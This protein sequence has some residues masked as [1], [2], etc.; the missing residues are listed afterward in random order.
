MNAEGL[1][2][3]TPNSTWPRI[4]AASINGVQARLRN[5]Q[6]GRGLPAAKSRFQGRSS[7]NGAEGRNPNG[8]RKPCSPGAEMAARRWRAMRWYLPPPPVGGRA[9]NDR[10]QTTAESHVLVP[11]VA[12][13]RG[14]LQQKRRWS[15][16]VREQNASIVNASRRTARI[17]LSSP[18]VVTLS[19]V[20]ARAS[21]S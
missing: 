7:R 14:L 16:R 17:K 2:A 5:P 9:R 10:K 12:C 18:A 4:R 20:D 11:S 3:T 15:E 21:D 6:L 8:M 1:K 19:T 13:N